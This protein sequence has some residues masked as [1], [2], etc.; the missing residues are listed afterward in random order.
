MDF[1]QKMQ[2]ILSASQ[3]DIN[4]LAPRQ[5][6]IAD[7]LR[8]GYTV[9]EIMLRL[10]CTKQNIH[11]VINN[12]IKKIQNKNHSG[13]IKQK[14]SNAGRGTKRIDYQYYMSKD[15]SILSPQERTILIVAAKN[16][17]KRNWEIAEMVGTTPKNVG[18]C[19]CNAV[20][21]L[22]G[23]YGDKREY[24]TWYRH[25]YYQE[26]REERREHNRKYNQEHREEIIARQRNRRRG[27]LKKS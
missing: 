20:K 4:K 17:D 6:Q 9:R 7:M 24:F 21:K 1:N 27:V 11:N 5:K 3:E 15:L 10:Y 12:V 18:V 22:N 16:P 23:T 13:H 25:K 14:R 19:L 2:I 8:N 26:H